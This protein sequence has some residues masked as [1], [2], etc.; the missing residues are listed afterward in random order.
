MKRDGLGWQRAAPAGR[1]G[2]AEKDRY[3]SRYLG[4][5]GC[6]RADHFHHRRLV[7]TE[8][9]REQC[10]NCAWLFTLKWPG[11]DTQLCPAGRTAV[12]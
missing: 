12:A 5:T 9:R 11:Q 2:R 4:G 6:D 10:R 3:S 8:R 1:S 7:V